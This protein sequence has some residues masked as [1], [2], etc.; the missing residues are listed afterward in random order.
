MKS[1]NTA[2]VKVDYKKFYTSPWGIVFIAYFVAMGLVGALTP[3][4][5]LTANSWARDFCNFMAGIVPQIDRVTALNIESDINRF[6]FS[7]MWAGSP[8]LFVFI[9]YSIWFTKESYNADPK[10]LWRMTFGKS[11]L[12]LA[13]FG[14]VAVLALNFGFSL[15]N[16]TSATR[17]IF[18]YRIGRALMPQCFVIVPMLFAG[19]L[20]NF[21][22]GWLTGYIPRNIK[23]QNELEKLNN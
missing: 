18:K 4:D 9:A 1:T 6:Y 8:L 14:L 13:F 20:F 16:S 2:S 11:I 7:V 22:A 15:E 10:S 17:A 19:A 12:L 3:A 21:L 23:K 5:I